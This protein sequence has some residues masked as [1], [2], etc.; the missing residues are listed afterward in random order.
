M[1]DQVN[2]ARWIA[3][4]AATAI[5]LYLCWLMLKPFIGV[6]QWATVLVIVFYPIHKRVAQRIKIPSL[7][8]LVSSALVIVVFVTP[9]ILVSVALANEMGVVGRNA[10]AYVAQFI[11]PATPVLGRLSRWIHER[12]ALDAQ[13]SEEFLLEQLKNAGVVLLG[14]SFGFVGNILGG[15]VKTFFVVF[16]VCQNFVFTISNNR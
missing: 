13:T 11:N 9:L 6:V 3:V 1:N 4:L 8:A 7:S 12:F 10:P 5:A 14:Q 16:N 2:K 15:I